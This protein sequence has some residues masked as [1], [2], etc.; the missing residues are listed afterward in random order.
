MKMRFAQ[1][2]LNIALFA[3]IFVLSVICVPVIR[4]TTQQSADFAKLAWSIGFSDARDGYNV[5]M[6]II[7]FAVA[8]VVFAL[9]KLLTRRAGK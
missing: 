9:I 2:L 4:F 6:G 1:I 3:T 5:M 8:L 7:Y